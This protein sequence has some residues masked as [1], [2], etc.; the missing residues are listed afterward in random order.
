M[1][2]LFLPCSG[3]AEELL[4]HEVTRL[5]G[6]AAQSAR[7]GVWVHGDERMAMRLNLQSR[8]AQRVL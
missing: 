1:T 4:T 8:L 3:G 6:V 7:G 5:T 2:L